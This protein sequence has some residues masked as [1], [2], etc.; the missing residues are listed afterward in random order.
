MDWQEHYKSRLTTYEDAVKC[1]KSGDLVVVPLAGPFAFATALA[2]RRAELEDVTV[3]LSS[4][5]GDAGWYD[6]EG[7]RAFDFEYELFIGDANR[8]MTDAG[9]GTYL[10]NI[11]STQMKLIDERRGEV[12]AP[13]VVFVNVSPPNAGGWVNFGVHMWNKRA[14]A[15]RARTVIA[16]VSPAQVIA[17]GDCWLHVTEIDALVEG[18]SSI[19]GAGTAAQAG[20]L[21]QAL[22]PLPESKRNELRPVLMAAE[23]S[24]LAEMLPA[25]A[26]KLG[27]YS[28][29][30][31]AQALGVS[32]GPPESAMTIA[33]Y[34]NS[35]VPDGATIQIGV[36]DPARWMPQAGAFDGK[37]DLGI[38]TELACPGLASLYGRGIV[39][40]RRKT[41]HK[42][43]AVAVAWTGGDNDD[44]AVV[45]DNPAFQ[46]YDPEHI[47]DLRVVSANDNMVA[48]NNAISVD[49][50]GQ[51]NSESVFGGRM[52]NGTGGQ[53]EMHIGAF[54]AKGGRAITL[55]PST[56]MGGAVSKI[57]AQLDA[58]S[59]VTIPRFY[60]DTVVTEYGIA[61]LAGKTHRQRANELIAVAHPDFRGELR[62]EAERLWARL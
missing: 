36:G 14:F 28:A 13:D 53:P 26:P 32:L 55:L 34:V 9:K 59:I 8:H 5:P 33:G 29:A 4:P 49:L 30:E 54:I 18:P 17:H 45:N 43:V 61:R 31:L 24:R 58:G 27:D 7:L 51:I 46:L 52:I 62:K 23:R 37:H 22:G 47:L 60:A 42:G 38:H 3:R 25:I 15:R 57:V 12:R 16:E 20:P 10:P 40:N 35:L 1:V 56:A 21:G 50:L 41:I 39:T 48:I 6:E 19:L 44:M 2:Q 11:F